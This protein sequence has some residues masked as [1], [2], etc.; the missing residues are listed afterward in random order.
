MQHG[1]MKPQELARAL[2][3]LLRR[4]MI[5]KTSDGG[6]VRFTVTTKGKVHLGRMSA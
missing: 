3:V 5:A 6:Q 2:H 1:K 4:G